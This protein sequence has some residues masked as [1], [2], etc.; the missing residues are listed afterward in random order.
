MR[1]SWSWQVWA[2]MNGKM[3][4]EPIP[5]AHIK[6]CRTSPDRL[7]FDNLVGCHKPLLDVLRPLSKNNPNGL[8]VILDDD[9]KHLTVA[10]SQARAAK[11]ETRLVIEAVA[12]AAA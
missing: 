7:D 9:D 12:R 1:R 4:A 10:Y 3:P 11:A 5:V 8:G 2:A 6:L